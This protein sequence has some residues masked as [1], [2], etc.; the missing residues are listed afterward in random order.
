MGL[1]ATFHSESEPQRESAPQSALWR[2]QP[3]YDAYMAA[4]FE[5]DR[6]QIEDR[7]RTAKQLILARE[8]EL[9]AARAELPEQRALNNA[10]HALHALH[11][12]LISRS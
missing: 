12:C 1:D 8:R 4:L 3:W 10:L 6:A 11:A 5:S 7:I 2:S 9:L